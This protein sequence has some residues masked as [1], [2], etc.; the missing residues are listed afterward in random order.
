MYSRV[1]RVAFVI[2]IFC[3]FSALATVISWT[4]TTGGVWS[5]ASSWSPN[6]IPDVGDDVRITN[7]GTYTVTVDTSA[8][9]MA[10]LVLGG[11]SGSQALQTI[12]GLTVDQSGVIGAHGELDL[13]GGF[14][15]GPLTNSGAVNWTAG[16]VG[17]NTV[18]NNSGAIVLDGA[19]HVLYEMSGTITN[20]GTVTL[21]NGDLRCISYD[22]YWGGAGLL[23]NQT[24]ASV[25]LENESDIAWYT[26][27]GVTPM[28][29]NHG[30]ILKRDAF[31]STIA[32][33]LEGNGSVIVTNGSLLIGGGGQGRSFS[34]ASGAS[35]EFNAGTFTLL[36]GGAISGGGTNI[37][38]AGTFYLNGTATVANCWLAGAF[39]SGSGS[40]ANN[41]TWQ[42]GQIAA[43]AALTVAHSGQ[44]TVD[45]VGG[46]TAEMSGILTNNGVLLLEQGILRCINY[47]VYG[48]GPG[49]LVNSPTGVIDIGAGVAIAEYHDVGANSQPAIVNQGALDKTSGSDVVQI[50][51]PVTNS[52][53]VDALVGGLNFHGGGDSPGTLRAEAQALIE[54]TGDYTLDASGTLAGPGTNE[55]AY[56]T[57]TLN[58]GVTSSNSIFSGGMLLGSNIV[59]SGVWDWIGGIILAGA[60][61]TVKS[62][63]VLLVDGYSGSTL[64]SSGVITNFGTVR[65]LNT[66]GFRFL[67]YSQYGGGPGGFYNQPGGLVDLQN[68]TV[69]QTYN[70]AG[71]IAPIFVNDGIVR[72]SAGTNQATF[73]VEFANQGLVDAQIGQIAFTGTFDEAGGSFNFGLNSLTHFGSVAFANPAALD[74]TIG[75]NF[76]NGYQPIEGDSFPVITYPAATGAFAG[77]NLPPRTAWQLNYDPTDFTLTVMNV[78]P[79]LAAITNRSVNETTLMSLTAGATDPDLPPQGLSYSLLSPPAGAIINPNSGVVTWT[80][81]QSES[82]ATNV[83]TVKVTDSGTP[84]L[85]DTNSFTVTVVE[86]NNGPTLPVIATQH[87]NRGALLSVT[88]TATETNIHATL[89]YALVNPP[90][91]MSIDTNGIITWTP[92]VGP[93]T[94]TVTTIVTNTDVYDLV[95]PHLAATNSFTVVTYAPTM[96]PTA[97]RSVNETQL[98]TIGNSAVDNDAS[99]TLTYSL[100]MAPGGMTINSSSGLISWIPSQNESPSVNTVKVKVT[101]NS[102][103][104]LSDTNLFTVTVVEINNAPTLPV[105]ATQH[106]NKGALLSVTNTATETNIHATVTY[107]LVAP[108]SGATIDANGIIKWTPSVG[109]ATNAITTIATNTDSLDTVTPHLL[110]TN[111]FTVV[112]YAPALFAVADTNIN[113]GQTLKITNS[114]TDN[115]ASRVLSFSLDSAPPGA[116]IGS[117]SGVLTWRAPVAFANTT[118]TVVVRVTDDSV[119]ALS[120]TQS[121]KV[122]VRALSSQVTL[123]SPVRTGGQFSAQASGPVGPD[124]ILQAS[125]NLA[126]GG[127]TSVQTNTPAVLPV[128]LTDANAA[129]WSNRFY[130]VKLGP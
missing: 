66:G 129:A 74:G 85:S 33:P 48:S 91:G 29:I 64:D 60:N 114:A 127:W 78:A 17:T 94:N 47:T 103:P 31:S 118:N 53:T 36:S 116:T 37:W 70:D 26:D 25:V 50:D 117:S 72:K 113:A 8:A 61:V 2:F 110:A 125:T 68:D 38:S 120:V 67:N 95:H 112:T 98:I 21:I 18:I 56:G 46:G 126:P 27:T 97:N 87:V 82:P 92:A 122:G 79:A 62:N 14:L 124:Y 90:S 59:T 75:V 9:E 3:R 123:S 99:R 30:T 23:V 52:G 49:L 24:N 13:M 34:V 130:R 121:F 12:V 71:T 1:V 65:V 40:F 4:N 32:A 111:T 89:A 119:P 28:V 16:S 93:A 104:P 42:F 22:V 128:T 57:F 15:Y 76:N 73:L 20:S 6:Q 69:V 80:P 44:L 10:S 43:D 19:P 35:L 101:D 83:I 96:L 51:A 54:F 105:I 100:D 107:A 84:Q 41:A 77:T 63:S 11:T 58:G 7:N 55:F 102:V 39:L 81:S 109:P 86:I 108:P 115:D 5:D 106:V 88:N 45:Y